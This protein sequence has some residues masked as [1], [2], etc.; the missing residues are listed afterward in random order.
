MGGVGGVFYVEFDSFFD[1][2]YPIDS[3]QP[4]YKGVQSGLI[5]LFF[6]S[7]EFLY[8]MHGNSKFV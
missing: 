5:S 8:P 4:V 7:V 2:L 6:T 1:R 3:V